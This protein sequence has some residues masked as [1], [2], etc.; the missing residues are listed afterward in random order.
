MW[1]RKISHHHFIYT[2]LIWRGRLDPRELA[3]RK[4]FGIHAAAPRRLDQFSKH[5]PTRLQRMLQTQHGRCDRPG[6]GAR[7]A[8][9]SDS[10]ASRS[11]RNRNDRIVK[12]HGEIVVESDSLDA[13]IRHIQLIC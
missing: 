10:A 13:V 3:I 1:L 7:Q 6:L 8:H 2:Q 12:V 9:D 4:R 5:S 11:R